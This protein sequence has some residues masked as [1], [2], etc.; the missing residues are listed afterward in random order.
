MEGGGGS[1]ATVL[2]PVAIGHDESR[3]A[4]VAVTARTGE[5]LRSAGDGA[6]P[7]RGSNWTVGEVGA[8]M[9]VALVA[10][11]LAAQGK[12]D[13]LAPYIPATGNFAERLRAVTA[14][15]LALVPEREPGALAQLIARRAEEFL[16]A[17]ADR[18]GD[19]AVATPWYGEGARLSLA[20]ATAMLVGEQLVHGYDIARTTRSPWPVEPDEAR[21]VIRALTSMMPLVAKPEKTAGADNSYDV[22]IRGGPRFVVRVDKGT[23]KLEPSPSDTACCRIS[24]DPVAFVLVAYGR[25]SQWGPIAKG[26][27]VAGGRRPWRALSFKNLFFNP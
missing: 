1:R 27:L 20:T 26:G 18:P 4:L 17:T 9:A 3:E 21:L 16:S 19:R 15:T 5:L 22:R 2:T 6:A 8:H 12:A 11:T 13:V 24:A 25:T 14:N 7:V 23:V 10:F